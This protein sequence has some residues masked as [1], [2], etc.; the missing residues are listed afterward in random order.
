MFQNINLILIVAN[1]LLEGKR[2]YEIGVVEKI[3]SKVEVYAI[4]ASLEALHL[5]LIVTADVNS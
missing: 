4:K 2:T 1:S 3:S 5:H